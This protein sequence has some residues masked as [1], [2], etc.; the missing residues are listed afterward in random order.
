[1]ESNFF[2]VV[3]FCKNKWHILNHKLYFLLNIELHLLYVVNKGFEHMLH[4]CHFFLVKKV[5]T[6][7]LHL[8]PYCILTFFQRLEK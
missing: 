2:L 5:L 7:R 6:R 8:E 3:L 4:P 1:M